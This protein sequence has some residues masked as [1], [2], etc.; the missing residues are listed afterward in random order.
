MQLS[1]LLEIDGNSLN[2]ERTEYLKVFAETI[3]SLPD[4]PLQLINASYP[5][6]TLDSIIDLAK[7]GNERDNYR[8]KLLNTFTAKVLDLEAEQKL[9]E[10]NA[11]S[12]KW[13]LPRYLGQSKLL[14]T[15]RLCSK[16]GKVNKNGVVKYLEA[17]ILYQKEQKLLDENKD[18]LSGNLDFLWN[19][20]NSDWEMVIRLE[21]TEKGKRVLPQKNIIKKTTPRYFEK[22]VA[23]EIQKHG[24][25]VQ[26]DIGCSGFRI[27]IGIVNPGRESEYILGIL[28]DGKSY[29]ASKTAKDREIIKND[30]LRM[31]G[32]N[33]YKLWSPDW[34]DNP[35]KVIEDIVQTIKNLQNQKKELIIQDNETK[36][37]ESL[38]SKIKEYSDVK[39]QG[40]T[41]KIIQPVHSFREYKSCKLEKSSLNNSDE[42][43]DPY[44]KPKIIRQIQKVMEIEA[45]ISHALLSRR[46]LNSWG[47][48]RLGARL[49]E[50]L[51][52]LYS[53]LQFKCTTQ[54]DVV[55]YWLNIQEPG[56]YD[57]FRIPGEDDQKRNAEDI[58]K[59]EIANGIKE[60]LNNQ[61]SLPQE[62][63]IKEAA[64]IFGFTRIGGNV[65]QVMQSGIDYAV[66]I[67][68][69][70]NKDM[71]YILLGN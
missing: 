16:D 48:S 60:V 54:N 43:F 20:G 71:R 59:E 14:K 13:F 36:A 11:A 45:P 57:I 35:Q 39:L 1:G 25:S 51:S 6:R 52:T 64:R 56:S 61:I 63:L 66:E 9:A 58:A 28:T 26:T 19:S 41:Q 49:N 42:F 55:F 17:L 68:L 2:K 67:N 50:Y 70:I 33:I 31:L 38:G 23:E 15:F 44:V 12:Q 4:I 22:M 18:I 27:D 53:Q 69:I 10:W 34:W 24:Y 62:D 5:G 21:Y 47:I 46:I 29:H 7:H 3:T 65:E 40:I 30:V 32:W 37:N 8:K